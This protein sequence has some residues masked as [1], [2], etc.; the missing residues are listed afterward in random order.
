MSKEIREKRTTVTLTELIARANELREHMN[1]LQTQIETYTSQLSELQLVKNTLEELPTSTFD[2][3]VVLDRLNTAFIPVRIS[4]NWDK[5]I[6]V[7]I[8]RNYYVRTNKDKA[9]KIVSDRI[10]VIRRILNDLRRQY[11]AVLMEYNT[12][13]QILAKIYAQAQQSQQASQRKG[14]S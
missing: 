14:A 4:D 2:G 12:I 8:G 13:Q 6:I 7:N 11:Q 3:L 1:V 10:S 5:N 9:S